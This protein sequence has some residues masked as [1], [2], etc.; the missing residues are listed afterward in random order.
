MKTHDYQWKIALT[1]HGCH[2]WFYGIHPVSKNRRIAICD[3]SGSRPDET[4]DGVI[5]LIPRI[6][7]FLEDTYG[8]EKKNC[9]SHCVVEMK[10]ER[11]NGERVSIGGTNGR[12]AWKL[13]E[14]GLASVRFM[15]EHFME[16]I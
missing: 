8:E 11:D 7:V 1:V 12:E 5:W 6:I 4:D 15:P 3:E 14:S 2:R 16:R 10:G 13:K 9:F